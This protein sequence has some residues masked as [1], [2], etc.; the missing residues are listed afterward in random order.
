M[1]SRHVSNYKFDVFLSHRDCDKQ[2]VEALAARLEDE[3]GL[4]P[5]LSR[6]HLVPGA[7]WQEGLEEALD[8]SAS[9]AVFVGAGG[10]GPWESA[11]MRVALAERFDGGAIRVIPVLLPGASI[12][13]NARLPRFLRLMS[14]I[15][16]R[17]GPE[18]PVAFRR[19][20]A[21]IRG[22][23][24]GREGAALREL[25]ARLEDAD[26][27]VR[28]QAVRELGLLRD[29]A[30]VPLLEKRWPLEPDGTVRH[31]MALALGVVGGEAAAEALRRLK[32]SETDRFAL[33]G[34]DDAL[35]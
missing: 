24:P 5:F 23:P 19:L 31:W 21:G 7:P 10:L 16:F 12:D 18:D 20:V 13:E 33:L 4:R 29:E 25:L 30:V 35:T 8:Q 22:V 32:A 15:D 17:G 9:C 27:L 28:T 2:F 11:E 14:W 3:A 1:S 26:S 34:I 6:W